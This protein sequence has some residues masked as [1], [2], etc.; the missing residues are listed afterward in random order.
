MRRN[1]G[2]VGRRAR[3][4]FGRQFAA[5]FERGVA[6]LFDLAGDFRVIRRVNHHRH[7]VVVFR[8]AAE[9]GRSADVNVLNRVV[10]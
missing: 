9:H 1:R 3:K 7:A 8:R 5:Q 6:I 4:N 2:V 10:Q